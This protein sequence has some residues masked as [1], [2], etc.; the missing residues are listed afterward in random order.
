MALSPASTALADW[1]VLY[2][3]ERPHRRCNLC[4]FITH[5]AICYGPIQALVLSLNLHHTWPWSAQS[6]AMSHPYQRHI[7]ALITNG[8][9]VLLGKESKIRLSLAA[10]FANG[11]LLI[12]DLPGVGKTMLANLVAR[13]IGLDFQRIQ[14]TSDLLPADITGVSVFNQ[15]HS[16]FEFHPGPIFAHLILVDEIN[17]ATPKTQSALLEAMEENQVSIDGETRPLPSP[18]F[19]IATQNPA[20]QAGTFPLPESQLDR[21][22]LSIELG[23]PDHQSERRMLQEQDPRITLNSMAP[24]IGKDDLSGIQQGVSRVHA[25]GPLLDYLQGIVEYSRTSQRFIN[26]YSP[27][28]AMGILRAAK[29]WAFIAGRDAVIPEDIQ[30][31][32]PATL[33]HLHAS[34]GKISASADILDNV[35]IP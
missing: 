31:I 14:F 32:I 20:E 2:N 12:N 15:P 7:D 19:V 35:A 21:F 3:T 28:A 26:G 23:Y 30:A 5:C 22:L 33:H 6:A 24:V 1:L 16:T 10:L 34:A 11:H 9:R 4:F 13:M 17:R 18:F 25:A 8:N 27:R 29:A